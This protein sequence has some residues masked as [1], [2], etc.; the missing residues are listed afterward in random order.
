M[1]AEL[2][3]VEIEYHVLN[4]DDWKPE[5]A[6]YDC[7]AL[8]FVHL[9]AVLRKRIHKLAVQALKPGGH[10]VLEAFSLKQLPCESGGPKVPELLYTARM[11]A[12]DFEGMEIITLEETQTELA[13]GRLHQGKAEVVHL[14]AKK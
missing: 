10:L 2:N 11:L 3:E 7:I 9:P 6:Q 4:L 8:I 1:L 13:E 5:A 14:F 12:E